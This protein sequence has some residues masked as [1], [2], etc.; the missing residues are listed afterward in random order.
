MSPAAT[1]GIKDN[2]MLAELRRSL[3][4]QQTSSSDTVVDDRDRTN[5][6]GS[7]S[8]STSGGRGSTGSGR[9]FRVYRW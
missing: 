7:S 6:T 1:T 4:A 9:E 8:S 5:M 2:D 3:Q